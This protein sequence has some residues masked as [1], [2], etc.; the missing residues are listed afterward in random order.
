MEGSRQVNVRALRRPD[1]NH[2][3]EMVVSVRHLNWVSYVVNTIAP[4]ALAAKPAVETV[5]PYSATLEKRLGDC[6]AVG[7]SD[8]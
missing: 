8:E 3:G 7:S 2:G 4:V 6:S 1:P 5:A